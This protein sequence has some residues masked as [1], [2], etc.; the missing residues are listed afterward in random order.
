MTLDRDTVV[1]I[2]AEFGNRRPDQVPETIDSMEL[3]WLVHRIEQRDNVVLDLDDTT[4]ARISTVT[5]AVDVL[6]QVLSADRSP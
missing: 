1:T 2:L 4:L 3:A 5:A 6:G